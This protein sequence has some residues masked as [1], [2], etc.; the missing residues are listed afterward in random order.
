M[1]STTARIAQKTERIARNTTIQ[2]ETLARSLIANMS[3]I[4][5]LNSKDGHAVLMRR[6]NNITGKYNASNT[7]QTDVRIGLGPKKPSTNATV[8]ETASNIIAAR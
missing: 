4:I 8:R 7:T 6:D 1:P 3:T 2:L 5:V